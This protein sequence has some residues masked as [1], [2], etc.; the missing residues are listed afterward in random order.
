MYLSVIGFLCN[1]LY[2]TDIEYTHMYF[3]LFI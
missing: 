3:I 2:N 1:T